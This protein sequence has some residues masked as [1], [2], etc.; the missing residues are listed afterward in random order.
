MD[1]PRPPETPPPPSSAQV[2][3][4]T[5][6]RRYKFVWPVLLAVNVAIGAYLF[7]NANKKDEKEEAEVVG[8]AP[9][10]SASATVAVPEKTLPPEPTIVPAI[11]PLEPIPEDEQRKLFK[12]MLEEKRKVKTKNPEEKKHIDEE[13]AILKQFIRAKSLPTI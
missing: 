1:P 11:T 4:E 7:L 5:A 2:P 13:K 8:G 12:W 9:A 10:S 3:K 6:A